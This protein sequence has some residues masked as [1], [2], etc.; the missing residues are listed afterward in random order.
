[1]SVPYLR[2]VAGHG[3]PLAKPDFVAACAQCGHSIGVHEPT[4]PASPDPYICGLCEWAQLHPE[5]RTG[6]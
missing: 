5:E 4:G 3:K 2:A 6:P 1:M